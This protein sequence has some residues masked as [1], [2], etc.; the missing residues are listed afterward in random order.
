MTILEW[1]HGFGLA[2]CGRGMDVCESE[3]MIDK[4]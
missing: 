1:S 4:S 2:G 3:T